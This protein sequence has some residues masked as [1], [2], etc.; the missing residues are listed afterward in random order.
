MEFKEIRLENIGPISRAAI[1]RHRL[2][3]FIGPNNSG[4]S[5]AARIIHG[6][7]QLDPSAAV[8]PRSP[9]AEAYGN[10]HDALLAATRS[11]AI[12][13]SAGIERRDMVTQAQASGRLEIVNGGPPVSLDFGRGAGEDSAAHSA[14]PRTPAP[15]GTPA[16]SMYVPAGRTGAVQSLLAI[17]QLKNEA[18][19]FHFGQPFKA[20]CQR[21]SANAPTRRRASAAP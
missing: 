18:A 21:N 3:V 2:S 8:R 6:V 17:L 12:L 7:R 20:D 4:K 14:P 19:Q 9:D 11:S 10:D 16:D 15:S 5:I 13:K 1:G